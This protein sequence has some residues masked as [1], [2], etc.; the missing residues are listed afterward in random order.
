[1]KKKTML[2]FVLYFMSLNSCSKPSI[3]NFDNKEEIWQIT[4]SITKM[5]SKRKFNS[6]IF[7]YLLQT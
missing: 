5:K 4:N 7:L 6:E 1:M 3:Q 2:Y